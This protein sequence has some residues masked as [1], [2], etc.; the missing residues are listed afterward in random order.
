MTIDLQNDGNEERMNNNTRSIQYENFKIQ[1]PS[2]GVFWL[3]DDVLIAYPYGSIDTEVG[4]A[5]SGNTYNHK[6]L[7]NVIKSDGNNKPYNY[8]P[9]GRVTINSKGNATIYMSPHIDI[10]Y[11]ADIKLAFGL[12]TEPKLIYDH[13]EHYKCF[14]DYQ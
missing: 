9:R 3:I 5:K 12:T 6:R 1:E 2:N 11:I 8:Y 4:V 14:Q 10:S 13:S 7:W